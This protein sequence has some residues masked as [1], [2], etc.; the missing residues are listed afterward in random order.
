MKPPLVAVFALVL[1]CAHAETATEAAIGLYNAKDYPEAAAV[2]G[3]IAAANPKNAAAC[4]YL[5]MALERQTGGPGLDDAVS[6][7]GKAVALAPE[8]ATYLADY[9][10]TCLL[11][12]DRERSFTY[13]VR[14]RDAMGKAIALNP[15]NL[16][17]R[18]GLMKFYAQA[19][20]PLGSSD[21]ALSQAGE[22]G[23]R[24]S[25]RGLR[26]FLRLA[27]TFERAGDHAAAREACHAALKL[28]PANASATAAL[29]RL[30]AP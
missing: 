26:A 8:N 22:I 14:G 13:A 2:L 4:Y 29:A 1:S 30:G 27:R 15:A 7:L 10:G 19:P 25:V 17:A 24:N 3:K 12:A 9:G 28:D 6:W 20:W 5:G 18:E 23:H 11:I 16:D 21:L